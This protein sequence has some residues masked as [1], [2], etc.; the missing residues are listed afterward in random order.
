MKEPLDGRHTAHTLGL[1]SHWLDCPNPH[2]LY[3]EVHGR[4]T[5]TIA[6]RKA[7]VAV[8]TRYDKTSSRTPSGTRVVESLGTDKVHADRTAAYDSALIHRQTPLAK[9][10]GQAPAGHEVAVVAVVLPTRR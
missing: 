7:Y 4:G 9:K 8:G 6:V 5:D 1:L 2:D 3:R 10:S